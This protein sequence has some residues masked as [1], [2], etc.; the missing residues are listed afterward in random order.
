MTS[1]KEA[2]LLGLIPVEHLAQPNIVEEDISE[3]ELDK[4][5]TDELP[6]SELAPG[7]QS[8][9]ELAVQSD[10]ELAP[11]EQSQHGEVNLTEPPPQLSEPI[12]GET[13]L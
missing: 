8:L 10:H 5:A 1:I 4:L 11:Y 2:D 13:T 6:T 3:L 9:H 7:N 12:L